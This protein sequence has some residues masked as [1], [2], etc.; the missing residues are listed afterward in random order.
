MYHYSVKCAFLI[1]QIFLASCALGQVPITQLY[2]FEWSGDSNV[3]TSPRYLSEFNANGYNNQPHFLGTDQLC[4]TLAWHIDDQTDIF[5]YDLIT[6]EVYPITETASHSE[7]S[8]KAYEGRWTCVRVDSAQN[9]YL[10]TYPMDGT[11][12]GKTLLSN[13]TKVGYYQFLNSDSIVVFL[14]GEP[15]KLGIVSKSSSQIFYFTSNIGRSFY[16]HDGQ[17][18]YLH[19]LT[20]ESW[21]IKSYDPVLRRANIVCKSMEGV[22]DFYVTPEGE[23]LAAKGAVIYKYNAEALSSWSPWLDLS[24]YSLDQITRLVTNEKYLI[25]VDKKDEE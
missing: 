15:N 8:P 6:N 20:D 16:V 5:Q 21:Y 13:Q 2:A 4:F 11:D 14:T 12:Q 10:W 25:V 7:Y 19:K 23:L 22:E 9:Q 18:L 17:I 24:M 1:L 3:V